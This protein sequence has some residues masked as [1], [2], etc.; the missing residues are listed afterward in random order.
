MATMEAFDNS[1]NSDIAL[2]LLVE[3]ITELTDSLSA[4]YS[5]ISSNFDLLR[6]DI[7]VIMNESNCK[8][9]LL[10]RAIVEKSD[11]IQTDLNGIFVSAFEEEWKTCTE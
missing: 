11:K 6:D 4:L 2:N 5:D 3:K 9:E 7:L 8:R 10:E 1:T